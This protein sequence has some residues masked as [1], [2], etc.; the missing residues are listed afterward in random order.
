MNTISVISLII[1]IIAVS[2]TV[3]IFR[4][5]KNRE[6][7]QNFHQ[8]TALYASLEITLA[9]RKLWRLYKEYPG[10]EFLDKYIEIMK[11]EQQQAN[12]LPP[13]EQMDFERHSLHYQRKLVS[14]FWRGLALL[15]KNN[16]LPSKI[17]Y[18]WWQREDIDIVTKVLLPIED[19]LADFLQTSRLNPNSDPLYYLVKV[20]NNFY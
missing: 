18:E 4:A 19:R 20:R 12:S 6:D 8:Q 16:L 15:L 3:I 14:Q 9:T 10:N 2:I 13:S 7:Y 11:S 5:N 17:A 1:S